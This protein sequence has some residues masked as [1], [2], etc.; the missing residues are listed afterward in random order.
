M[1]SLVLPFISV[2]ALLM[3][4]CRDP[5]VLPRQEPDEEWLSGRKPR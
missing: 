3:T 1:H 5:G 2:T 4:A